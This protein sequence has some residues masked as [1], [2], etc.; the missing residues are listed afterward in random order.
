MPTL[1]KAREKMQKAADVAIK[2]VLKVKPE[3][4]V[5]II[6]NPDRDVKLISEALY[7]STLS[8]GG[9]PTLMYQAMKTQMEFAEDSVVRAIE[10]NPDVTISVSKEKLG[11]DKWRMKD[12]IDKKYEHVFNYLLGEKK[13]RSFWSPSITAKMFEE[14]IPLDYAQMQADA[15]ALQQAFANAV[16]VHV[17]APSGTDITM[18]I[19]GRAIEADDGDFS[20]AGK[21]GNL[22]AGEVFMG[23]VVGASNGVIVYDG[24]ISAAKGEIII[25]TPIKCTVKDGFVSEIT[26]GR[27]SKKLLKTITD[28]ETKPPEMAKEGKLT[29]EQ[30]KQYVRNARNIGELGIGLNRLAKIV[31]NMLEDE[32]VYGTCHFAI[33]SN[34]EHDAPALIHLDGLVKKPTITVI[35]EDGSSKV[36]MRDGELVK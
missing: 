20:E 28:A 36:V 18:N 31:G 26:G 24:S 8:A 30:A 3:E 23:P 1:F 9:K 15:K 32:K 10:S 27:E 12:P 16:S 22:P 29:E 19:K 2:E 34:Y 5:L 33:G 17:G 35:Y 6:T 7:N 11:K 13:M 14:T 21:G 4:K 25:K